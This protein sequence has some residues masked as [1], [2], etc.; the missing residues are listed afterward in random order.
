MDHGVMGVE[1]VHVSDDA[2][3]TRGAGTTGVKVHTH[4]VSTDPCDAP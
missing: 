3:V 4:T 2:S 1:R